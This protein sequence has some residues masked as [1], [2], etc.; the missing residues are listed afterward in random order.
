[1]AGEIRAASR[2]TRESVLSSVALLDRR[3]RQLNN[4]SAAVEEEMRQVAE[5]GREAQTS[6]DHFFSALLAQVE[7]KRAEVLMALKEEQSAKEWALLQQQ[8]RLLG[9]KAN[10]EEAAKEGAPRTRS[11]RSGR[12]ASPRGRASAHARRAH[13]LTPATPL[14][15]AWA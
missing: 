4:A 2:G 9:A 14:R 1:M 10:C 7:S 11:V 6:A 15:H 5:K 3:T 12:R 8:Q 13:A